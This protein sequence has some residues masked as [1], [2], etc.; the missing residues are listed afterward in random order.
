MS[1]PLDGVRVLDLTNIIA[2]PLGSLQLSMLGAEVIKVEK[3]QGGDLARKMGT[4]VQLRELL[5]GVSFCMHNA[6]K[7]SVTL[8]LKNKTGK[9][10][11]KRLV[12]DADVV[13]ENY[14]PGVMKKLG[15]DYPVLKAINPGIIFCAVSGFGQDG[16]LAGRPSYDQV[17]Q[18][19]SGLMSLTGT[20]K[21]APIRSAYVVCDSMAAM[22][23][24]FAICAALYRKSKTG[25]GDRIDVSM[26]DSTLSTMASSIISNYLNSGKV[27]E[28]MGNENLTA[29][30]S[31]TY[32]TKDGLINIVNNEQ[33]QYEGLCKVIGMPE[34][35]THPRYAERNN[36][37]ENR[38]ELHA[39][40]EKVTE[41]RTSAEWELLFEAASVPA[42]P[43]L[44]VP[45]IMDH[46]QVAHRKLVRS[47]ENVAGTGRKIKVL[48]PGFNLES[49]Q[50]DS[51]LPPPRL[52]QDNSAILNAIGYTDG[53]IEQLRKEG[54][55]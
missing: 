35:I 2:G 11:F 33:S 49:G 30:P 42:G 23:A 4:D 19:F 43:I 16:P 12:M 17:I 21:T 36:R 50:P 45:Q 9:E 53:D 24:A 15:L 1:R 6:G 25:E 48:R 10:I 27:P 54:A 28:P 29:S 20:K 55:V 32:R 41:T 26:L 8:N 40:I 39:I 44:T 3:P 37:I 47:Y 22:T 51:N 31:G 52:G 14:R 38:D 34:L 7:K 13:L 18:G 5:M 46:P